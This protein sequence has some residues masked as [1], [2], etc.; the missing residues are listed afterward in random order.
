MTTPGRKRSAPNPL[1]PTHRSR[2]STDMDGTFE[3][4]DR[5][6]MSHDSLNDDDDNSSK[7]DLVDFSI[8]QIVTRWKRTVREVRSCT[9]MQRNLCLKCLY[10][11]VSEHKHTQT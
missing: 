11:V 5:H 1:S 4:D 8:C 10:A 9:N 7:S 3:D 2:K 6:D